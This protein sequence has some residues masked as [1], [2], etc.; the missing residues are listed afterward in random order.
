MT[1]IRDGRRIIKEPVT[2]EDVKELKAGDI[3]YYTGEALTGRDAVHERVVRK[4]VDLPADISEKVLL[5][6]GPIVR[7]RTGG[8]YECYAM[9]P[10]TSMRMEDL[11]EEFIKKTAV[12]IIVG[13]GAMGEKTERACM[14]MTAVHAVMPA[15]CAVV[16]AVCT[17][18]II[19]G[20]WTDLGMPEAAWHCRVKELGPLIVSIDTSGHN[21]FKDLSFR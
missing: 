21:L 12:K 15:G 7:E 3:F 19:E 17:E 13:K 2:S 4:G 20:Y 8:G 16:G 1:E 14:E 11:E 6:A 18:E 5:H 9:G 10:T